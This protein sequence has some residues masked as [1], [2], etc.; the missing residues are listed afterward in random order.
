MR[1]EQL[2]KL[3]YQIESYER[4]RFEIA[5]IIQDNKLYKNI[6]EVVNSEKSKLVKRKGTNVLEELLNYSITS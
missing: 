5:K 2:S 1:Q 6:K 4:L 3:N